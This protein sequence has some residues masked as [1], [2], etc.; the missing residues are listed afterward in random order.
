MQ[1]HDHL[2]AAPAL[3]REHEEKSQQRMQNHAPDACMTKKQENR[4]K[5][6]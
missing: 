3:V 5:M 4:G 1:L 6:A 2:Q